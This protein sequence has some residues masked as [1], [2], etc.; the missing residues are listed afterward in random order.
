MG[1]R[2][3]PTS[4][5]FMASSKR[6]STYKRIEIMNYTT[7]FTIDNYNMLNLQEHWEVSQ[8]IPLKILYKMKHTHREEMTWKIQFY[9]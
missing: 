1:S 3:L 2:E 7:N 6:T 9:L 8:S 5:L 4:K